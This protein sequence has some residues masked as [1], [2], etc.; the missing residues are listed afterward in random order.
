MRLS[1]LLTN[2]AINKGVPSVVGLPSD[3][4][5]VENKCINPQKLGYKLAQKAGVSNKIMYFKREYLE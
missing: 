1:L 5:I 3:E 2:A 4:A